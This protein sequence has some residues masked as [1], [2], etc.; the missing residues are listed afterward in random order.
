MAISTNTEPHLPSWATKGWLLMST[1][2]VLSGIS[3]LVNLFFGFYLSW[4]ITTLA[5]I[6]YNKAFGM[7]PILPFVIDTFLISLSQY[8]IACGNNASGC[9]GDMI[10]GIELSI[11]LKFPCFFIPFFFRFMF[12]D[13]FLRFLRI[14]RR[15]SWEEGIYFFVTICNLLLNYWNLSSLR[16]ACRYCDCSVHNSKKFLAGVS[17]LQ[18]GMLFLCTP[19]YIEAEK[20]FERTRKRQRAAAKTEATQSDIKLSYNFVD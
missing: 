13:Q 7:K 16:S 9:T 5:L 18:E 10:W 8:I 15:P 4:H 19:K 20:E 17:L 11:L 12:R 14:P 1:I 2:S 3:I 6:S